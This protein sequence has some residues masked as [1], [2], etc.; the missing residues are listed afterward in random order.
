[1]EQVKDVPLWSKN[2]QWWN[3]LIANKLFKLYFV[4]QLVYKFDKNFLVEFN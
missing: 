1:M 4:E 2:P 3:K